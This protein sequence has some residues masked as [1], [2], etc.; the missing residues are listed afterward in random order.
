MYKL[1]KEEPPLQVIMQKST[2]PVPTRLLHTDIHPFPIFCHNMIVVLRPVNTYLTC[3]PLTCTP[4]F[5][6]LMSSFLLSI[7]F[8]NQLFSQWSGLQTH[9]FYSF[10]SF[11]FFWQAF[12][13]RDALCKAIYRRMFSWLIQRVNDSIKV[14]ITL[15]KNI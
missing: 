7:W 6:I 5:A 11:V 3:T 10:E 14:T 15:M 12:N 1:G 4:Q 9:L 2:L 8:E 13:A